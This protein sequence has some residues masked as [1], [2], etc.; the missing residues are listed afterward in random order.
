MVLAIQQ[1][2]PVLT[3]LKIGSFF[4]V[5]HK[6][7]A[8]YYYISDL[9]VW[10]NCGHIKTMLPIH[11]I[12]DSDIKKLKKVKKLPKL[13]DGEQFVLKHKTVHAIYN[14]R[15][16]HYNNYNEDEITNVSITKIPNLTNCRCGA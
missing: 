16:H 13:R 1:Q 3:Q 4:A 2:R 8:R 11:I 15:T 12:M 5:V 7:Y 10:N 9:A 14:I 6:N